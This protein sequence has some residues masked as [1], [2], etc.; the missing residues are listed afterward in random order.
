[1]AGAAEHGFAEVDPFDSVA[2]GH[3]A[4]VVLAVAEIEGVAEF[5]DGFFQEALA[6]Q[7]VVAV[8]A[9]ELLV[10]AVGGDY[11]AR[12]SHLSFAENV[13][14]NGDVE[15]EVGDG[16]DAPVLRADQ[17]LHAAEDFG[18]MVLLAL[19]VVDQCGIECG[20]EDGARHV[21]AL[22][23]GDAEVV[24]KRGFNFTDRKQVYEIHSSDTGA[25]APHR[26]A[27]D[28]ALKGRSCTRSHLTASSHVVTAR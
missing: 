8:E 7:G 19:G 23:D 20:G 3:G 9:V 28:T 10:E 14:E 21:Q 6:E 18:R 24:E 12:A 25:K 22:R 5:V 27:I 11:G 13:L 26:V 16:E 17:R 2:G 15:I 1:M 4:A